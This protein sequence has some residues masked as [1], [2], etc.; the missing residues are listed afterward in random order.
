MYTRTIQGYT[1]EVTESKN[2]RGFTIIVTTPRRHRI[3]DHGFTYGGSIERGR[4][5]VED[6]RK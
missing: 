4:R 2:E 3:F 1:I 6:D 5:I